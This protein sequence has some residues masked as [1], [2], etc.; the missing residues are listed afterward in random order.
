MIGLHLIHC[1]PEIIHIKLNFL[2]KTIF[3]FLSLNL[4]H[5]RAVRDAALFLVHGVAR[6]AHFFLP[7]PL[8]CRRLGEHCQVIGDKSTG[9]PIGAETDLC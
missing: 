9:R 5:P 8:R 7:L 1:Y 4:C 6:L 2:Q 3:L